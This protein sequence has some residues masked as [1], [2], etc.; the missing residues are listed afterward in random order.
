MCPLCV[1]I[2]IAICGPRTLI[3]TN[4]TKVLTSPNYP[5]PFENDLVC[6][7]SL[8]MDKVNRFLLIRFTDVDLEGTKECS[9]NYLEVNYNQV[10][11]NILYNYYI[12]YLP[13][14]IVYSITCVSTNFN[15][16]I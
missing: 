12:R 5:V 9:T 2:Y 6:T 4:Q 1:S 16:I 7:W 11:L 14:K 10:I 3:V 13:Y 8:E 15:N